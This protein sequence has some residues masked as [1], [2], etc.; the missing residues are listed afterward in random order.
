MMNIEQSYAKH[1]NIEQD[2]VLHNDSERG[3]PG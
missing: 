2:F 3:P 1:K